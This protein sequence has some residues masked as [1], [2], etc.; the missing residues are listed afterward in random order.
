MNCQKRNYACSLRTTDAALGPA[1]RHVQNLRQQ[2]NALILSPTEPHFTNALLQ[3]GILNRLPRP[4]RPHAAALLHHFSSNTVTTMGFGTT[5]QQAWCTAIPDLVLRHNFVIHGVLAITALHVSTSVESTEAKEGYQNLVALELNAGLTQFM[6]E[7]QQ[8]TSDNVEALFAFSTAISIFNSFQAKNECQQVAQSTQV[9]S[10]NP[11]SAQTIATA[12][13]QA[14]LR[15]LR[16][17][18]GAQVILVPGWGKLQTGPLRVVVER[19][20]W[21]SAI[22]ISN[23]H[24]TEERQLKIL[25][26][27][28]SSP[29]RPYKDYFGTLRQAWQ[30]LCRSF[31]LVWKLIDDAPLSDLNTSGPTFDW[32]SIFHFPVQC[33]L[34]FAALLE[35][36]CVEAWV[37]V[38]HY[39]V[40]HAEVEGLW[41]LDESA[42]SILTTSALVI[43]TNNWEWIAWP[44]AKIGFDLENL[45]PLALDRPKIVP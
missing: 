2:P 10:L 19:D 3:Q 33:S 18:R 1:T 44:A 15:G 32:T 23:A 38:G 8:V 21:S 42:A 14:A 41:W 39:A 31:A 5:P 28:W 35:E 11:T 4:I 13:V 34:A 37:L 27:M 24:R 30:D 17:L 12:A 45:R 29:R 9:D 26:S 6:T 40:Q 43:G 36:Q 7:L 22:P 20:S 16:T 25:E